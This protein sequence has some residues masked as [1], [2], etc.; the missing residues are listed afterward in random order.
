VI[1]L[2]KPHNIFHFS[3]LFNV[4]GVSDVKQTEAHTEDPMCLCPL[5]LKMKQLV[6][7]YKCYRLP[8]THQIPAEFIKEVGQFMLRPI[9]FLILFGMR[10]NC[11][12]NVRSQSLYPYI[13]MTEETA[14][15]IKAY[16][17]IQDVTEHFY[18]KSIGH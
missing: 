17:Y 7:S 11:F 13:R 18:V 10:K 9:N 4:L 16:L 3:Q 8:G 6:K 2:Q 5:S 12:R 1:H 14:L 15:I